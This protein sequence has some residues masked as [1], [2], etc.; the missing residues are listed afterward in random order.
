MGRWLWQSHGP[1]LACIAYLDGVHPSLVMCRGYYT[2][3]VL[4]A[5]DFS[6]GELKSKWVFDSEK[7]GKQWGGQ[8]N[9]N[10]TVA[11]VD[12]DGRDEIVYG[13]MTI[14][15]NG[16]GL[17][18]TGLG[19]G[20]ALH[21]TDLDPSRPGLEVFDIQERF[22]DAGAHMR[23]ARTGENLWKKASVKAGADGEGPGRG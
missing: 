15:D 20:D 6:N 18:T 23:D 22:D 16:I 14:D 9:H 21:V 8:G 1:L 5:W 17:Y 2:R 10:L 3:T 4:A 12:N 11:D 19:H 13:A 7:E